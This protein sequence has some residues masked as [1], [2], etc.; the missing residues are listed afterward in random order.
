MTT[1]YSV[2]PG[3][4]K[5]DYSDVDTLLDFYETWNVSLDIVSE[6]STSDVYNNNIDRYL[7]L[8]GYLE[9]KGFPIGTDLTALSVLTTASHGISFTSVYVFPV[10]YGGDVYYKIY[11]YNI[12]TPGSTFTYA[13][14]IIT[15]FNMELYINKAVDYDTLVR[16]NTF[17][18]S[19]L[20]VD[21]PNEIGITDI[22]VAGGANCIAALSHVNFYVVPTISLILH[23]IPNMF[24]DPVATMKYKKL[25]HYV[26]KNN[27]IL[28]KTTVF[29]SG[30]T[31]TPQT[32]NSF[33]LPTTE[34]KYLKRT[35]SY[36]TTPT[37]YNEYSSLYKLTY[38]IHNNI[39]INDCASSLNIEPPTALTVPTDLLNL[40]K[41]RQMFYAG[42]FDVNDSVI[43]DLKA[44]YIDL[45]NRLMGFTDNL[46]NLFVCVY[47]Q[48]VETPKITNTEN[49]TT[50]THLTTSYTLFNESNE[51][52]DFTAMKT[53]LSI[54]NTFNKAVV[55]YGF[56]NVLH[57]FM[58]DFTTEFTAVELNNKVSI[59][60]EGISSVTKGF[61]SFSAIYGIP[62][63]QI[64]T[65]N[66]WQD[67]I[68]NELVPF[69]TTIDSIK[70]DQLFDE[71][72]TGIMDENMP[73]LHSIFGY[74]LC[75]GN[76]HATP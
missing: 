15:D 76:Y 46:G 48:F 55:I 36:A 41:I 37:C 66:I 68:I 42:Y 72:L 32:L 12:K 74:Q 14:N 40:T 22:I 29:K 2:F 11:K 62:S 56:G 7:T 20:P 60:N 9:G 43:T 25:T 35:V 73:C 26:V 4:C 58:R 50:I 31:Y 47:D 53:A 69:D 44:K 28:P 30:T 61:T 54:D 75:I 3:D 17:N 65:Y 19:L 45:P 57:S 38:N 34:A 16:G 5:P 13:L 23:N 1:T 21:I 63:N 33:N 6:N 52:Y 8:A 10:I 49:T 67:N 27:Y 59:F 64:L 39:V 24:L 18:K 51:N 70:V 71:K